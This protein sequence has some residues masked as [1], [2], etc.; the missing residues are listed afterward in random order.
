[1]HNNINENAEVY[2]EIDQPSPLRRLK[3][4]GIVGSEMRQMH[5]GKSGTSI[6]RFIHRIKDTGKC[7]IDEIDRHGNE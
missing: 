4:V 2:R 3:F 5:I 7:M 1:M 6:G